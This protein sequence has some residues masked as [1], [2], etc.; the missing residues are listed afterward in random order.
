MLTF[1]LYSR[2]KA[3]RDLIELV[4]WLKDSFFLLYI[5]LSSPLISVLLY[6]FPLAFSFVL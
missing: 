5:I 3:Y 2:L 6:R 4:V 1:A